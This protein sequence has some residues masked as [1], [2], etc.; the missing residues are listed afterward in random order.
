MVAFAFAVPNGR[1]SQV[2]ISLGDNSVVEDPQGFAPFGK[3]TT[4]MDIVE[5]LY[6]GYGETSGGG[7][8]AGKQ[9][10]MFEEGNAFLDREYPQLDKILRA[11]VISR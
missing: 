8:R 5:S 11:V 6:S 10:P 7:I 2:F 9:A 4:G 1:T 3:V